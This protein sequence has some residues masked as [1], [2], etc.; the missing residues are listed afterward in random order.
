M[1][2]KSLKK[3]TRLH[4]RSKKNR[5]F[6]LKGGVTNKSDIEVLLNFSKDL[7]NDN[8]E[9]KLGLKFDEIS[10][11]TQ[12]YLLEAT[13]FMQEHNI[14]PIFTEKKDPD[15]LAYTIPCKKTG[16]MGTLIYIYNKDTIFDYDKF[17]KPGIIIREFNPKYLEDA[18]IKLKLFLSIYLTIKNPKELQYI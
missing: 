3:R 6:K 17:M 11:K 4:T 5:K 18:I 1:H 9:I 8:D 10:P 13:N 7:A 14:E 15:S 2:K 16:G 12:K